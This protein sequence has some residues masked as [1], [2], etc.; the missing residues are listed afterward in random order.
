VLII[1][2]SAASPPSGRQGLKQKHVLL[3][4]W[5]EVKE[6]STDGA[7]YPSLPDGVGRL[8]DIELTQMLNVGVGRVGLE[9]L[10]LSGMFE[11]M[12]G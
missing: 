1:V 2:P 8:L 4:G 3:Y 5:R 11:F 10:L 9:S 12:R 7:Y 6:W